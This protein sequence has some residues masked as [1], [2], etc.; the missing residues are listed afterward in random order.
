MKTARA[1]SL[2]LAAAFLALTAGMS[3][4]AAEPVSCVIHVSVDGL[5]PDVITALGPASLPNFHRLRSEGAFT[6]NA[7][8]DYDHTD[9]LP[10]HA[11]QLTSRGVVGPTGHNWTGNTDPEPGATI[12]SNKGSYVAC[13]FDVAHDHGLRTGL[14]TS[15]TKFSL[16]ETSWNDAN[17]APDSVS[18]DYGKDKIDVF[19]YADDTDALASA[20]ITNMVAQPFQYVFL[21][22]HNPDAAG[23][24]SGWFVSP[25]NSAYCQAVRL[26]DSRLGRIFSL[27]DN[28][29]EFT[30]R[31]AIILTADHGGSA[32]DHADPTRV[33]DY[34]IPFYVW[35][36]GIM[37]GADLYLMNPTNRLNPGTGRPLYS[38]PL[39]PIRNG[40][41]ANVAL[42]LLGLPAVPGSTIGAAQDLALTVPPPS[43]LKLVVDGGNAVVSFTMRTNV[44]YDIQG[45][46]D[47]ASGDWSG[48]QTNISGAG[49]SQTNVIVGQASA[50]QH[51]YRLKLHF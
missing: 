16:F 30:G 1:S 22:L 42:N 2:F 46:D 35:G 7:R 18:P 38:A 48:I 41:A 3:T 25:T 34:T 45:R 6:D 17:G 4:P 8:T 33:E 20:M 39:Q 27:I 31:T 32:W 51:F 49:E 24:T 11:S 14:Y 13:V 28:N 29:A 5:R 50:W 19:L 44:L 37:P 36:P 12:H 26:V 47:L 40:E 23:H 10:N 21:H 43:D 9:T 15:K